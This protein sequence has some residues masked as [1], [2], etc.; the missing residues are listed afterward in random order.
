[1]IA[2]CQFVSKRID[3]YEMR[4]AD[5]HK[6]SYNGE[7]V[8]NVNNTSSRDKE[9]EEAEKIEA[10][11]TQAAFHNGLE[12]S[13]SFIERSAKKLL[14]IYQSLLTKLIKQRDLTQ[15]EALFFDPQL[16]NDNEDADL[17]I[18]TE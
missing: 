1:M 13:I 9:V 17:K 4:E 2:L 16:Y 14:P 7:E 10:Y 18:K 5:K 6:Q 15:E 11:M 8:G 12:D 3:F